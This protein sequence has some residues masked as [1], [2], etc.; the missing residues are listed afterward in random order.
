MIAGE[1]APVGGAGVVLQDKGLGLLGVS[2]TRPAGQSGDALFKFGGAHQRA[3]PAAGSPPPS[4]STASIRPSRATRVQHG[5]NKRNG[6]QL[7]LAGGGLEC[8]VLRC[9]KADGGRFGVD[10]VVAK[11]GGAAHGARSGAAARNAASSSSRGAVGA[12]GEASGSGSP[13]KSATARR[14]PLIMMARP[15]PG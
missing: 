9:G 14:K 12:S 3:R 8:L 13:V 5:A 7:A 6:G 1:R 2:L 10:R 11:I 4:S 15:A